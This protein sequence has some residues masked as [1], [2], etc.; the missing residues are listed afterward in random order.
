[1]QPGIIQK[2]GYVW[3][4]LPREGIMPLTLLEQTPQNFFQ[5]IFVEDSAKV[6]SSTI[7]SLFTKS[8][9][10]ATLPKVSQP[11]NAPFFKGHDILDANAGIDLE[12]LKAI[13]QI[14]NLDTSAKL[15]TSAKLLYAFKD[16]KVLTVETEVL[17]EEYINF[18]E[19]AQAPGFVEKLQSGKLYVVTEVLQTTAFSIQDASDFT[20][21]GD[22]DAGAI[23]GYLAKIKADAKLHQDDSDKIVYKGETPITFALKA[24]KILYNQ[25][26]K[27][28]TLASKPIKIVKGDNGIETDSLNTGNLSLDL[29]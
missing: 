25:E 18:A 24:Y 13:P 19:L 21:S 27:H 16:V 3:L 1:M 10:M 28:Y 8:K 11:K 2:M 5:R 7:F 14:A 9:G 6:L 22:L 15:S 29:R 23:E 12:G 20:I 4:A 17:L 26:K